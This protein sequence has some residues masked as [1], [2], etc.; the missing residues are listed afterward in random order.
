MQTPREHP[1][2][3]AS[4]QSF[5]IY[6]TR[7]FFSKQEKCHAIFS[8]EYFL[9]Y[10]HHWHLFCTFFLSSFWYRNWTRCWCFWKGWVLV[11]SVLNKSNSSLLITPSFPPN[12]FAIESKGYPGFVCHHQNRSSHWYLADNF[13]WK[14]YLFTRWACLYS[15]SMIGYES[16][17]FSFKILRRFPIFTSNKR[18][19]LGLHLRY[20]QWFDRTSGYLHLSLKYS[21]SGLESR[22]KR[23]CHPR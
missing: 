19:Y 7:V 14:P 15:D 17:C 13:L 10:L 21:D 3:I 8:F 1:L 5:C 23:D 20:Y 18:M 11:S 12:L 9:H 2:M 6:V 4:L 16:D 22:M